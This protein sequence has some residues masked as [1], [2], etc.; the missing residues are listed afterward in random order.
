MT[1]RNATSARAVRESRWTLRAPSFG[2]VLYK[3]LGMISLS[4]G[5]MTVDPWHSTSAHIGDSIHNPMPC[6]WPST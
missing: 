6:E 2:Y 1:R 3:Q 4:V 5:Y